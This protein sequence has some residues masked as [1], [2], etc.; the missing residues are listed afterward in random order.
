MQ[1]TSLSPTARARRQQIIDATIATI[2]ELGYANASFARIAERAGLSST[3]LISYHFAGKADLVGAVLAT[4]YTNMGTFMASRLAGTTDP[5]GAL[6]AYI[7]GVVRYIAENRAPMTALMQIFLDYRDP[8]GGRSYEPDDDRST[9]APLRRILADGQRTG[10]FRDF[11]TFV[12][13]ATIQRAVDGIPFLLASQPDIDLDA[14]AEEL[15]EIFDR[16]TRR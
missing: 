14:Y 13:A 15:A 9:L 3:R 4:V 8:S 12:M 6:R 11:D 1:V 7:T 5:A 16:A 10:A 2:A